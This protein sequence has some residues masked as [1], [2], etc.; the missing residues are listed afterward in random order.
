MVAIKADKHSS[1]EPSA[2]VNTQS[3]QEK[4]LYQGPNGS[5]GEAVFYA[6]ASRFLFFILF[7]L[8]ININLVGLIGISFFLFKY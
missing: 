7:F 8:L 6:I 5:T 2:S 3:D 4:F 1:A